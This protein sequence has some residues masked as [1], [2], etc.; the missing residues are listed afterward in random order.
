VIKNE[1]TENLPRCCVYGKCSPCCADQ[2][3]KNDPD[4]FPVIF[5][6]GHSLLRKTSPEPLLDMF[7]KMQYQ[8]QDDDFVNAGTIRFDFDISDYKQDEWGL[9]GLPVTVKSSYYY[10]YF[11]S[12]GKYIYITRSTDNIDTYAVRLNDIIKMLKYRTG[13]PKVN[14]IAHSMGG[15]VARRYMQIFGT[16]SVDKLVLIGTPNHGIEGSVKKFCR[17]FGEKKECEDMYADSIFMKK[18]NAPNNLL[19]N[20]DVYTISGKGCGTAGKDG[21]GIVTFESSLVDGA[22]SFVVEGKCE[23]FFKTE[24]H[25]DLLNIDKYPDV[26][27]YVLG[28]LRG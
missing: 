10:D 23:D 26:Y 9:S 19:E 22:E 12:L 3:C 1:L 24:L 11:Y 14:I 5:V 21:D 15:L 18:L 6:H 16:S 27:E 25:S 2:E 4:S 7:S 28:I 17:L 8:L 20:T 13:K